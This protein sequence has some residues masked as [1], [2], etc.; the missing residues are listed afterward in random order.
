MEFPLIPEVP[1]FLFFWGV[2]E[3]GRYPRGFLDPVGSILVEYQPKP[4]HMD[5]IRTR[6]H[7]FRPNL[8]FCNLYI[9]CIDTIYLLYR[10]HTV[11][12]WQTHSVSVWKTRRPDVRAVVR[13]YSGATP[14]PPSTHSHTPD[15]ATLRCRGKTG[16][17]QQ[18]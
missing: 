16:S 5:L 11:S 15:I 13:E 6:F 4:S 18:I 7:D 3:S 12:L 14:S 9:C 10:H 8:A 1:D 17:I 2:L